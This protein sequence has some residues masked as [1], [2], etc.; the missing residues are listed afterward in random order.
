MLTRHCR[1][2]GLTT[3]SRSARSSDIPVFQFKNVFAF[4]YKALPA[5]VFPPTG[6]KPFT[7]RALRAALT[8][9]A[10][11]FIVLLLAKFFLLCADALLETI[12]PALFLV[13]MALVRPV[14][15]FS[16]VPRNT[17]ERAILPLAMMLTFLAFF[18][19]RMDFIAARIAFMLRMAFMD[20]IAFFIAS[21]MS[22]RAV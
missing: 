22:A 1:L 10:H 2:R 3:A 8:A 6:V 4:A 15:V 5:A 7:L 13:S 12:F 16:F 11:A 21:A 14:W 18:M 19:R 17:I 20:F 9:A